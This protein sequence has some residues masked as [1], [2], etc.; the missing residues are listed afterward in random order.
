MVVAKMIIGIKGDGDNT[1]SIKAERAKNIFVVGLTAFSYS[2]NFASN[3]PLRYLTGAESRE[4]F[5][6]RELGD[7]YS[8]MQFVS[9]QL[10]PADKVLFLWE[11]RSYYVQRTIQPDT[12]LDAF[13]HLRW[14]YHDADSIIKALHAA[15]Y[16]HILLDRQGLDYLLQTGYDP[17]TTDDIQVLQDMQGYLK[18]IYGKTPLEVV[19]RQG[20]PSIVKASEDRYALYEIIEPAV[21][22]K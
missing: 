1:L 7:Y 10:K 14:Q 2:L 20:M 17:I 8:A 12:I 11:P 5:L 21:A 15:G 6:A 18:Q 19:S 3:N 9:K 13:P 22:E 16:T 4:A